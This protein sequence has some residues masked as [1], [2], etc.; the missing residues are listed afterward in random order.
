M[1]RQTSKNPALM[2]HMDVHKV[3][4]A[5]VDAVRDG[6]LT[7]AKHYVQQWGMLAGENCVKCGNDLYDDCCANCGVVD[8]RVSSPP[9]KT[10]I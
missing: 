4:N 7:D 6:D 5:I 2:S 8:E 1:K 10:I 9:E 3:K